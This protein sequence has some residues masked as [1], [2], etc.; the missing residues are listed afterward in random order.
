VGFGQI[1][2]EVV[3]C[4][5]KTARR[6]P[7]EAIVNRQCGAAF[8]ESCDEEPHFALAEPTQ[9]VTRPHPDYVKKTGLGVTG[10]RP[11]SIQPM[12]LFVFY[13]TVEPQRAGEP[14]SRFMQRTG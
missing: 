4:T 10:N 1:A 6:T 12:F 8:Q 9:V 5:F 3:N 11:N 2:G 7:G 14:G 13:S